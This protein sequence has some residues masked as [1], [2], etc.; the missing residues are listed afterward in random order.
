MQ[1]N[2]ILKEVVLLL[3]ACIL[4]YSQT[5]IVV[6][7]RFDPEFV[8]N[9]SDKKGRYSYEAQPYVCHWNLARLAEALGAEL[10]SAK[11]E[12]ILDEFMTIYQDFYLGN[13]RRKLG[14]L[15]KQEP[16]D[17][18]LVADLL[19][20]MHITGTVKVRKYFHLSIG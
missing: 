15:R 11:A 13:M 1:P 9:A 14:L 2:C 10:Q 8:C 17:V 5:Y 18:E 3:I 4:V 20:T 19:K 16:E 7:C 6:N 12:A